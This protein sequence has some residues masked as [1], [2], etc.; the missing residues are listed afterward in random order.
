MRAGENEQGWLKDDPLGALNAIKLERLSRGLPL[1]D[2]SMINPDLLP[3][4]FLLDKLLEATVKPQNHRY[5]VSRGIRKLREAFATKYHQ[6]FGVNLDP[7][8]DVCV[9]MGTKDALVSVLRCLGRA[10]DPVAVTEPTYPAH[11]SAIQLAGL[12]PAL[13]ELGAAEGDAATN[14]GRVLQQTGARIVLLNLPNNPTGSFLSREA[15][16]S[17][18]RCARE[19]GAVVVNDFVYGEMVHGGGAAPSALSVAGG[20]EG[21]IEV[22][23]ISKAYSVP[24]WRVGAL[25]GPAAIVHQ[26][27]RLKS[28]SDYG[29]FLPL[30]I[31]AAAALAASDDL[32]APLTGQYEYRAR[33]L[34]DGLRRLGRSVDSPRAGASVWAQIPERANELGSREYVRR[35]VEEAGVFAMPGVVFG[36][37]WDRCVRFALVQG[38]ERLREALQR[39]GESRL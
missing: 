13:F 37:R 33:V 18:C 30:Q 19:F 31:A 1:V 39:M 10:G 11:I 15:L 27:S 22:Y 26:V 14:L 9:T 29:V 16:A 4:R 12:T 17:V 28:H 3:P 6:R 36:E 25:V 2:L 32:V 7:E 5:A 20:E 34:V 23:S 24:G 21:V 38:E 35:L 8:R